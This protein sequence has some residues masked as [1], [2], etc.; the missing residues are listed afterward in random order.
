MLRLWD[1]STEQLDTLWAADPAAA[2]PGDADGLRPVYRACCTTSIL[3]VIDNEIHH[4]GQGYVYLRALGH[5][6]AALLRAGLRRSLG[7]R[8][9]TWPASSFGPHSTGGFQF[10][11]T[12]IGDAAEMT[13]V[14]RNR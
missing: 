9:W 4:R 14:T 3:Y 12:T 5:R 6:A 11:T 1:E 7:M 10:R 2:V 13:A 8:P